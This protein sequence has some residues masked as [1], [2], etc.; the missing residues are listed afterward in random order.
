MNDTL[1]ATM[2]SRTQKQPAPKAV[3]FAYNTQAY[4][5]Q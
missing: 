5:R 2:P 4:F 1:Q 3:Q